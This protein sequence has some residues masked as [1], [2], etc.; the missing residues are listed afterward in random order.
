MLGYIELCSNAI[1]L[2][3]CDLFCFDT[4]FHKVDVFSDLVIDQERNWIL[5]T[6]D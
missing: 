2:R 3:N 4:V 6:L 5:F 1:I